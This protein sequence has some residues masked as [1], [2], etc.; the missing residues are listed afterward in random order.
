MPHSSLT[1]QLQVSSSTYQQSEGS[2]MIQCFHSDLKMYDE[3][4]ELRWATGYE[5]SYRFN[6]NNSTVW[7]GVGSC[8]VVVLVEVPSFLEVRILVLLVVVV[9]RVYVVPR[10]FTKLLK[11]C[12][13]CNFQVHESLPHR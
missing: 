11:W 7:R 12:S 13:K 8:S 1:F 6:V 2:E 3:E 5:Q 9:N 4:F 10:S